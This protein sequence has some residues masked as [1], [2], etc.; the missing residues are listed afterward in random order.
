VQKVGEYLKIVGNALAAEF[1]PPEDLA[2]T[3]G[4]KL[5]DFIHLQIFSN[6]NL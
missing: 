1:M 6:V 3:F 2:D 4:L 5:L